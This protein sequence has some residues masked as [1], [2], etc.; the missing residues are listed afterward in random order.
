THSSPTLL[1]VTIANIPLVIPPAS[2]PTVTPSNTPYLRVTSLAADEGSMQHKLD[3]LTALCTSLQR[4]HSKMVARFEAQGLEIESLKVGCRG[5][6]AE[7][8]SDDTKEMATVLTSMDAA[9]VLASGVAEVPTVSGSIPTAGPPATG[10]PTSSDVVP[11]ACN[12]P[13]RKEDVTS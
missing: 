4:Q 13:L 12:A 6:A 5:E 2:I 7:R 3:E 1:L 10:V 11:T 9:T 8:V